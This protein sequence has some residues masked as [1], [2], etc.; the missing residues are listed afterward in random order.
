MSAVLLLRLVGPK[1]QL[2]WK[3]DV[4]AALE[5]ACEERAKARKIICS[6]AATELGY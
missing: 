6:T 5:I 3:E 1:R 2:F 4:R